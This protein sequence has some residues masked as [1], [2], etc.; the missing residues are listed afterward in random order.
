MRCRTLAACC[1]W[2]LRP[3]VPSWPRP[4]AGDVGRDERDARRLPAVPGVAGTVPLRLP[5]ELSDCLWLLVF[6]P[7]V[8]LE[9]LLAL[10]ALLA[11]GCLD[12]G[13]G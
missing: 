3:A 11:R 8:E 9:V 6:L 5:G 1:P 13:D 7:V 10:L 4:V 2:F 12:A